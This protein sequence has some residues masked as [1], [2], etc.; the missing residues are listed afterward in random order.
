VVGLFGALKAGAV[1][2]P[3]DPG[4]P[5]GRL[6]GIMRDSGIAVV[7]ADPARTPA[8]AGLAG[9]VPSFAA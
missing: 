4:S 3:L 8:A 6:A 2:V 5:A 1:Y 9:S 7:L